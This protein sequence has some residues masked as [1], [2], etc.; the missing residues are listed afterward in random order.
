MKPKKASSKAASEA[1][2]V[3]RRRLLNNDSPLALRE[4]CVKLRT[5]LMVCMPAD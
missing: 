2:A 4:A 3:N 5:S 1:V